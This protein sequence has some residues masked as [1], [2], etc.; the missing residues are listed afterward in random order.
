MNVRGVAS[1]PTWHDLLPPADNRHRGICGI[2]KQPWFLKQLWFLE[3]HI[4]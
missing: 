3:A 4:Q 2:D 1:Q